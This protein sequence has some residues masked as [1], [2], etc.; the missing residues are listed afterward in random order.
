MKKISLFLIL[1]TFSTIYSQQE[2]GLNYYFSKDVTLNKSIPTPESILGYQVGEWH[3]S[4][5]QVIN[6]LTILSKAS[7]RLILENRGVTHENRPLILLTITSE[8]NHQNIEKIKEEHFKLTESTI[9]KN[10]NLEKMPLV[11]N[12]GFSVHGN[13]ASG[14]N[15]SILLAYYL[16]AAEGEHIE[17][18]LENTIILLDP[19]LNPDGYQRFSTWVNM[20]KSNHL[21]LDGNDR[22]FN[23]VWPGGRTNH[24]WFD[25]NRDWLVIQQ[26]ESR[27]RIK[28]FHQW[29]PNITTD[30]HEMGTN[31][32][33]FFQPGVPSS[34][35]PLT[36][37]LNQ[38][39]TKE[40]SNYYAKAL[41]KIGSSYFTEENYDDFYYGK[42]STYPDINGG[43]GILFEQASSRGSAQ[44]TENGLLTFPIAIK[45]QLTNAIATLDAGINLRLDL[46]N[47][48]RNFYV[49]AAKKAEQDKTKALV[50]YDEKDA[51]KVTILAQILNQHKIKIHQLKEDTKLNGKLFKQANSYVIPLQQKN[52][53]LISSMF[54]KRTK[55][56]D[57]LFY[58]ISTW[59]LPLA[60]N[61]TYDSISDKKMIGD[62]ITNIS[63]KTKKPLGKSEV[64]YLFEWHDYNT[65]KALNKILSKGIRVK[66]AMKSFTQ[67]GKL[68]DF[69]TI[70]IP[71]QNQSISSEEIYKLLNAIADET[72][73]E[74]TPSSTSLTDGID[75][76]S[77]NFEN[78]KNQKVA[79]FVGDGISSYDAGEIWHLFDIRYQM[80]ITKLD[81]NRINRFNLS[82]YTTLILPSFSGKLDIQ[83]VDKLKEFVQN[84]GILIGYKNSV[85][86][87]SEAKL[88]TVNLKKV[89]PEMQNVSFEQRREF[90]GA[91]E[92]GG[93]IF[94]VNLDRSHPINFGIST[95]KIAIFRDTEIFIEPDSTHFKH[96]IQY[97]KNPLISGYISNENLKAIS[98]TIPFKVENLGRGKVIGLTDN[99]NFRAFWLGTD[100]ILMNA[101]FFGPLM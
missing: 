60:F 35:H 19:S 76:G 26:P 50:F 44:N 13:E 97:T 21:N 9:S 25:L 49:E 95:N 54:E 63:F 94:E 18:I 15:A 47:Y 2:L 86:V 80:N 48:Q 64:A 30:F 70:Q 96:P 101:V 55:F 77:A 92:I 11:I 57:S 100:K 69:G 8:K 51:T 22:E 31:S 84:G 27:V 12:Q 72:G 23:E 58:D 59:T 73:I 75:L 17:N 79:M 34:T 29:Y 56:A 83:T 1:V 6:Y 16:A 3:P 89:K 20:H 88:L 85:K 61:V 68:F 53:L 5:D 46:L 82:T 99:V 28:T 81:I 14:I 62:E 91:Q 33:Y 93:A 40:I 66:T 67:N 38:K 45:N 37:I 65:P 98:N 42:G 74:I 32:T 39:L 7:S 36:P 24:Y 90:K 41:D 4:H 87:L 43:I 52:Y 10:L 71:V 78:I